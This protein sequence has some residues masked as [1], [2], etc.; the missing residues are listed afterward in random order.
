LQARFAP[1]AKRELALSGVLEDVQ[2]LL[3][4]VR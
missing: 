3:G 4:K 1:D 2:T